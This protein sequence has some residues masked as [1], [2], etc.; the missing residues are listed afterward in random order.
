MGGRG[1]LGSG[2][3]SGVNNYVM[4]VCIPPSGSAAASCKIDTV[5]PGS[6]AVSDKCDPPKDQAS[7]AQQCKDLQGRLVT[8]T[9]K[10]DVAPSIDMGGAVA[11]AD[12]PKEPPIDMGGATA[13]A[14]TPKESPKTDP[15]PTPTPAPEASH[16]PAPPEP[17][18]QPQQQASIPQQPA[19]DPEPAPTPHI[20][21]VTAPDPPPEMPHPPHVD[22]RVPT[23]SPSSPVPYVNI[24]PKP[25]TPTQPTPSPSVTGVMSGGSCD[26]KNGV[27][28]CTD[29][30]GNKCTTSD[31]FCDPRKAS[32]PQPP[33]PLP[34]TPVTAAP[35]VEPSPPPKE[36][37]KPL[38]P[39]KV[40]AAPKVEP[41]PPAKET[42]KLLPPTHVAAAPKVEPAPPVKEAPKPLPP[43][44]VTAAPKVEPAPPAKETPKPLP[45]TRVAAAPKVEPA[46]PVKE[47]PK[48]LPP[49]R[50]AAVP[51]PEPPV[52][53]HCKS[54]GGDFQ[55]LNNESPTRTQSVVGR[56][57]CGFSFFAKGDVELTGMTFVSHPEQGK[58]QQTDALTFVYQPNPGA[59]GSDTYQV[60]VC[61][62][63]GGRSG[64]SLFTFE[65]TLEAQ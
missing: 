53:P 43:T 23:P 12:K 46:P 49:T 21:V 11:V 41:A 33:K 19:P 25:V 1:N 39:T 50:V 60:R 58:L 24:Y 18:A 48:P 4:S 15:T 40:T 9:A 17:P 42:P 64:C 31:S 34:P 30:Q 6:A 57:R 54:Q 56:A 65:A 55:V 13:V 8:P 2:S 3:A 51:P 47:A 36:A 37:P 52:K 38:P 61:G 35:K 26:T 32:A 5:T 27:T 10:A 29:L 45:P 28:T 16:T 62:Q 14:D 22:P 44:P 7:F 59:T 63:G 20:N